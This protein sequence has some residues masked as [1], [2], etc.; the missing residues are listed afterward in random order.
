VLGYYQDP[1]IG[2]RG[3]MGVSIAV[4]SGQDL[5][6]VHYKGWIQKAC[7]WLFI[8][9]LPSHTLITS[10]QLLKVIIWSD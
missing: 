5:T 9:K 4:Q 1:L 6:Q 2:G 10:I 8:H 3:I 7:L